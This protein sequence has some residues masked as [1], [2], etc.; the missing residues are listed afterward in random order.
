MSLAAF[1][2]LIQEKGK[3]RFK[4]PES[5]AKALKHTIT[6]SYRL[7]EVA[8]ESIDIVL[9]VLACEIHSL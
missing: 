1:A 9:S 6:M 7:G 8:Q 4:N 5:L 3:D 2:S